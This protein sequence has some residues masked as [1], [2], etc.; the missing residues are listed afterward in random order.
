M[1]TS[2]AVRLGRDTGWAAGGGNAG[3]GAATGG[4]AGW[5]VCK[6]GKP[7]PG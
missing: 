7:R 4:N 1:Y 6:Y 2:A 3:A 5:D